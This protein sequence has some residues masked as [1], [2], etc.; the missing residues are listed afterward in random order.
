MYHLAAS[1]HALDQGKVQG[2]IGHVVQCVYK[3]NYIAA[4]IISEV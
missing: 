1:L 2:A 3:D 4:S